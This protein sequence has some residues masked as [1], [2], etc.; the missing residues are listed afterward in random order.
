[1][2]VVAP[3]FDTRSEPDEDHNVRPSYLF[4]KSI[5]WTAVHQPLLLMLGTYTYPYGIL[6]PLR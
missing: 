5:D 2:M 3:N 1:M 4:T 6:R